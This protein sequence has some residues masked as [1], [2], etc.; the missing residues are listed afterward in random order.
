MDVRQTTLKK[1]SVLAERMNR[2][3]SSPL[4]DIF[5][6]ISSESIISFAG[7]LPANETFSL[8]SPDIRPGIAYSS[9]LHNHANITSQ[10]EPLSS[11]KL[12]E[13]DVSV[14]DSLYSSDFLAEVCQYGDSSGELWLREWVQ[15]YLGG[16]DIKVDLSQILI[17]TGSQQGLDLAAKLLVDRSTNVA[18]ESP[19]YLAALQ[20]FSLFGAGFVPLSASDEHVEVCYLNPTFQNPTAKVYSY[21]ERLAVADL[22]KMKQAVLIEDDPYRELY[23]DDCCRTPICSLLGDDA[24]WIY[25][26]SFSKTIAPGFRVGFLAASADLIPHLV[27]LKQAADLHTSRLAQNA[28]KPCLVKTFD[29]RVEYLRGFYR[30]RRDGFQSVLV[31]NFTDIADWELPA[32]GMFFWL[33][34]RCRLSVSLTELFELALA[35]GVAFMPG[36]HFYP[37]GFYDEASSDSG[38][39]HNV[40]RETMRLNFTNVATD[41]VEQGLPVL[42]GLIRKYRVSTQTAG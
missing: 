33:K 4:R 7:G 21:S 9:A 34:L 25:Q 14:D 2:V 13:A 24:S 36:E 11:Q 41:S 42:A 8:L 26:S 23:Y 18:I 27:K 19:T 12:I 40:S 3:D 6:A 28:L 35:E 31:E 20:C 32:G 30:K 37:G 17:V 29:E 10:I 16:I 1:H 38:Q 5:K 39:N 22:C 15:T